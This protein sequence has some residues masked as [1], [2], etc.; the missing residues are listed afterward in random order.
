MT[1]SFSLI[2]KRLLSVIIGNGHLSKA[3]P[4]SIWQMASNYRSKPEGIL[5]QPLEAEEHNRICLK[6]RKQFM[7]K[8]CG[9]RLCAK[10]NRE[11]SR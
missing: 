6:C 5:K 11:N 8:N 1:A 4:R 3:H 2:H 7:S 9:H 10:C